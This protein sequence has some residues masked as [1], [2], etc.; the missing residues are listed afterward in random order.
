MTDNNLRRQG[1]HGPSVERDAPSDTQPL[2][3][4]KLVRIW[5]QLPE[6]DRL[7]FLVSLDEKIGDQLLE[8]T[9]SQVLNRTAT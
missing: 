5:Q 3:I 1:R 4:R 7:S 6:S 2:E 9:V 8:A